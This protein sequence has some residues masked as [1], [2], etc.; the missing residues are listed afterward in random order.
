MYPRV[1]RMKEAPA[2]LGMSTRVFNEQVRPF[3]REF[4]VGV[5][6]I[7]FDRKELDGWLLDYIES[8]AIDKT[9]ERAD[10]SKCSGVRRGGTA[11]G[12]K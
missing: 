8:S 1:L 2:Y 10:D 6:G 5:Q 4:K 3:V 12:E 7:G 11:L 9:N